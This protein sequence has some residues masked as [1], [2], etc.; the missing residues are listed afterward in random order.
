MAKEEINT[1][2]AEAVIDFLHVSMQFLRENHFM[3]RT[4]VI[5]NQGQGQILG[6]LKD[7][8][9]ISQKELVK[10]LDMT[11]QSAGEMIR[12]LERKGFIEKNRD[13]NDGR[14]YIISLTVKG[15]VETNKD[16]DINPILLDNLTDQEKE[17][18]AYLLG[19]I[20][21]NMIDKLK[22]PIRRRHDITH[23]NI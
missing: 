8:D 14:G 2:T 9:R 11:P 22:K 16:G 17:Q 12:K 23:R 13:P 15:R 18:L 4:S 1:K 7:N 3:Q 10:Q 21:D 5:R 20:N 19:K 6:V